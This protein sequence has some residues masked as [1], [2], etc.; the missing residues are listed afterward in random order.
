MNKGPG[1]EVA[2]ATRGGPRGEAT[3]MQPEVMMGKDLEGRLDAR[4]V[5]GRGGRRAGAVRERCVHLHVL[6]TNFTGATCLEDKR[7]RPFCWVLSG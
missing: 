4:P 3:G 6:S 7:T 2:M 1:T 5:M